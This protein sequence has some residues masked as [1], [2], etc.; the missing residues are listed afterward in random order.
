MPGRVLRC[1]ENR[2]AGTLLL[3]REAS[4]DLVLN[5]FWTLVLRFASLPQAAL[6]ESPAELALLRHVQS[7]LEQNGQTMDEVP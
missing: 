5:S 6:M 7:V 4:N 1:G 2:S 3:L